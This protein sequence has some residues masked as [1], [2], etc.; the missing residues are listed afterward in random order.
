MGLRMIKGR[1]LRSW[2]FSLWFGGAGFEICHLGGGVGTLFLFGGGERGGFGDKGLNGRLNMFVKGSNGFG[3]GR[4]GGSGRFGI[5][6]LLF[7][8]SP[9]LGGGGGGGLR[10][11]GGNPGGCS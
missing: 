9:F 1:F 11:L 6:L 2:I 10:R 5:G 4:C 7:K 8:D 3:R